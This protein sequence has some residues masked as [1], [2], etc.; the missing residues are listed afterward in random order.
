MYSGFEARIR[1]C[2]M[3]ACELEGGTGENW[4]RS[5]LAISL[6]SYPFFH[7]HVWGGLLARAM[8]EKTSKLR[9]C[10]YKAQLSHS[11]PDLERIMEDFIKWSSC[12]E[13]LIFRKENIYTY[14]KEYKAVKAAKR[15]NDVYVW[16]LDKRLKHLYNLPNVEFFNSKDRNKVQRTKAL[17]VTFTFRREMRLDRAWEEVGKYFNRA[18]SGIEKRYG[19]VDLIR[20]WEAQGDGYPHIHCIM[21]F[22][23][24]EFET[25]FYNGKWRVRE[26]EALTSYWRWGFSDIFA[27]YSLG[28]GVGYVMKYVTKVNSALLGKKRDRNLVLSLALMWI[29]SKRA[30]S[31]SR[32]FG[33][34]FLRQVDDGH[35]GQVDLEGNT[36]YRWVLVGFWADVKGEYSSWSIDLSYN[37]FWRI[38]W[39]KEFTFNQAL[40]RN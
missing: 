35:R 5:R 4:T 24:Y 2:P 30:F 36:I 15:G 25:F 20:V 26:K 38:R 21:L 6:A 27:L 12:N 28:A 29:F 33:V 19:K 34:F 11:E 32:S 10:W 39:S 9:L 37:G 40:F 3:V 22:H 13:Y 31:V 14:E 18:R 8:S 23:E 7:F 1:L 17:F 16:K